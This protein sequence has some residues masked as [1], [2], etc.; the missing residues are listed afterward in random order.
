M[1]AECQLFCVFL[2]FLQGPSLRGTL[3]I[4]VYVHVENGSEYPMIVESEQV[5][6]E[7]V[8]VVCEDRALKWFEI[9]DAITIPFVR[10]FFWLSSVVKCL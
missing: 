4:P 8:S 6:D 7:T 10:R 3:D 1:S 9:G 5:L 2:L